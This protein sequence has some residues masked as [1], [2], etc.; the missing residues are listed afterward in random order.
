[1]EVVE[2]IVRKN[3]SDRTCKK[4]K[5]INLTVEK[6]IADSV[7]NEELEYSEKYREF[8]IK[9]GCY[10]DI[11]KGYIKSKKY[12]IIPK[13]PFCGGKHIHGNSCEGIGGTAV[14]HSHCEIGAQ[15][16]IVL[17]KHKK[18]IDNN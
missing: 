17:Y 1:M 13:C 18:D 7:Y 4:F 15:Y 16:K 5:I 12:I 3:G 14:R 9:A 2:E 11:V 6:A 10:F 8:L